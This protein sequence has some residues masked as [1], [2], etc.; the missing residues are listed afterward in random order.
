MTTD[1][2]REFFAAYKDIQVGGQAVIFDSRTGGVKIMGEDLDGAQLQELAARV[3]KARQRSGHD[4]KPRSEMSFI[5]G[6]QDE[7]ALLKGQREMAWENLPLYYPPGQRET[8]AER[9]PDAREMIE[10]GL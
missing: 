7:D 3:T 8:V 2:K 10:E 5:A 6:H 9:V 1:A 4:P